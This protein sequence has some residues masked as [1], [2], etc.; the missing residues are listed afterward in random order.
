M[1]TIPDLLLNDGHSIPHIGFGVVQVDPGETK[2]EGLSRSVGVSNVLPGHPARLAAET[3]V[4]PAI[5]QIE[6]W[7]PIARGVL[8]ETDEVDAIARTV[9]RSR[10]VENFSLFD[11]P[12]TE[13]ELVLLDA[14][15]AGHRVAPDPATRN[16]A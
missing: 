14:L 6:A 15:E 12:L 13:A 2:A 7:S 1:S 16:N 4:V 5:N 3:S 9:R 10:M 8:V 11:F